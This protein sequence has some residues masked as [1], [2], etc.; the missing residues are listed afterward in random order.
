[1]LGFT[2]LRDEAEPLNKPSGDLHKA[3]TEFERSLNLNDPRVPGSLE[4]KI[5]VF[6]PVYGNRGRQSI[7]SRRKSGR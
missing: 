1:M 5:L 7:E 3:V 4:P 2:T 6:P